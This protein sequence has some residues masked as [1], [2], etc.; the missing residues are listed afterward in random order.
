MTSSIENPH[1]GTS[2]D[3]F[4]AEDGLLESINRIAAS[5]VSAW[6]KTAVHSDRSP[7]PGY[8]VFVFQDDGPLVHVTN[9]N[10]GR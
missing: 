10:A 2:L 7:S 4:L 3:D 5:R 8:D 6:R 9:E 1:L